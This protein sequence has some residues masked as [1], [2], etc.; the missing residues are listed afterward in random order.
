MVAPC[1]SGAVDDVGM[2]DHPADVGGRPEDLAGLDAELVPHRP[3]ERDHVAAIV[4]HDALGLAGRAGGVEDVERIGGGDRH[5]FDVAPRHCARCRHARHSRGR[6]RARDRRPAARA[7]GSGTCPAA[8]V[9]QRDRLVEQRLVGDDAAGLEAAGRRDHQLRP[10]RRRC[11]S[12][13][14]SRRSRRTPPNARRRCGR[15]RAWRSP[16]PA[17]IGM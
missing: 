10:A 12:P 4:A 17:T 13:V 6:G 7:A 5:A 11:G 9:G 16:L 14:P 3:F 1:S 8:C 2:A 15:R